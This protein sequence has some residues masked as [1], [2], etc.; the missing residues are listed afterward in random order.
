MLKYIKYFMFIICLLFQYSNAQD[1]PVVTM[2]AM[3][4][5]ASSEVMPMMASSDV[6][7]PTMSLSDSS[8]SQMYT[9][10]APN[11]GSIQPQMYTMSAPNQ[12]S[13]Q[14]QMYAM[15]PNQVIMPVSAMADSTGVPLLSRSTVE[16]P[17]TTTMTVNEQ[18]RSVNYIRGSKRHKRMFF[19]N[20]RQRQQRWRQKRSKM[21]SQKRSFRQQNRQ[22]HS[23]MWGHMNR[24]HK[25][26]RSPKACDLLMGRLENIS[27]LTTTTPYIKKHAKRILEM[28]A[29]PNKMTEYTQTINSWL[30]NNPYNVNS[31]TVNRRQVYKPVQAQAQTEPQPTV[32]STNRPRVRRF[33]GRGQGAQ[34]TT[35]SSGAQTRRS[36]TTQR[37]GAQTTTQSLDSQTRR[38]KTSYHKAST[39]VEDDE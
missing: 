26:I 14:P 10:S 12:G 15:E 4:M 25:I 37:S 23:R 22:R 17:D 11:Q 21:S 28:M 7:I 6:S 1:T 8:Q 30:Q 5:M 24:L 19:P 33:R 20:K 9:M 27:A 29:D 34:T 18:G 31:T 3:P 39:S 38:S 32:A 36:K 16:S 35:Q 13:I 2:S